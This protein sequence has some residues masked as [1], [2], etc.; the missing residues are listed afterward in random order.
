MKS[1]YYEAELAY[2]REGGR[3]FARAFPNTAGL[4]AERSSDADVERLLEGFAFLSA[5]VRERAEDALPEIAYHYASILV[6]QFT[7]FVPPATIVQFRPEAGLRTKVELPRGAPLSAVTPDGTQC[8][9][10]TTSPVTLLPLNLVDTRRERPRSREDKIIVS[11]RVAPPQ[12]RAVGAQPLRFFLHGETAFWTSLRTWFLHYCHAIEVVVGDEVIGE[13]D[14]V[15]IKPVG[16]QDDERLLPESPLEH[17]AFT[18]AAEFFSFP[19][20][21]AYVDIPR[22]DNLVRPSFELHF[23]F[24]KAPK[25]PKPPIA[26]DIRLHCVPAVNLFQTSGDPIRFDPLRPEGLVRPSGLGAEEAEIW[27]VIEVIGLGARARRSYPSFSSFEA[28]I[29]RESR[30]FSM[31]RAPS[32]SGSGTD[33]YLSLVAPRDAE[34]LT[35]AEV[36]STTVL[37]SNRA[38]ACALKIGQLNRH[39]RGSLTSA[40]FG[41]ITP[42]TPPLYP[43]DD[44]ELV[45][46]LAAHL[47]LSRRGLQDAGNLQRLL[48]TYNFAARW[49]PR[50]GRL[51]SLWIHAVKEVRTE[52]MVR[53]FRGAPVTG[54]RTTVI[55]DGANFSCPG[56]AFMF[57][58]ILNEVFAR[59]VAINSFNQFKLVITP[60]G[61]QCQWLPRNGTLA[62]A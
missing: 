55:L 11:M 48:E 61:E 52:K 30:F 14:P 20:K 15:E 57:G 33:V 56:E 45:W 6:P 23:R 28:K 29:G 9:F 54:A 8:W 53:V 7:R 3:E 62:L 21:F 59:R 19:E 2:L 16:H 27:D 47:G 37:C 24:E 41:N 46:R 44:V 50:L 1:K 35:E 22:L 25:L 40:P 51:N 39:A 49:S 38:A 13:L 42:V 36:L 5:R 10:Q 18:K 32:T 34:P 12:Q 26:G 43:H 58:E 60:S 31:R 4:L 17:D